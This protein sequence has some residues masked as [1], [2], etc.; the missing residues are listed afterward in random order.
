MNAR[1]HPSR[2]RFA[3]LLAA[4]FLGV[5]FAACERPPMETEQRNFRGLAVE[6][7]TN[8]RITAKLVAANQ[9]PD[10]LPPAAPGPPSHTVYENVQVLGDTSSTEFVRLMGAIT[11]WVAQGQGCLYC[12]VAGEGFAAEGV[13]TKTVARRMIQMTQHINREWKEHVGETG[14]TCYTCH[15]G[16]PVP[17]EYWFENPEPARGGFL[18]AKAGQNAP[19]PVGLTSLPSDPFTRFFLNDDEIR[20][21][22]AAALPNGSKRNIKDTEWT[23]SLMVHMSES[24]GVNCTHCHNSRAFSPWEQSSPQRVKAWHAIRMVR[25]INEEYIGSLEDVFPDNRKGPQGDVYKVNC[26]T[27]HAGLPLPLLGV[28]MVAD[29]PNLQ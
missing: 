9:V 24:L 7:V 20:V 5:V 3:P 10:P 23:Y 4:L 8:P 19:G 22:S 17:A 15:R 6:T 28:S 29:Y 18:G 21:Q 13:Y 2:A 11:T 26:A 27:C 25:S 14:V 1:S 12:H 16:Q